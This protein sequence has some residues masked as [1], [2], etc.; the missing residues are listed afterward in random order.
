MTDIPRL[1]SAAA[2][3]I[4][5]LTGCSSSPSPGANPTGST[6]PPSQSTAQQP[7][8]DGSAPSVAGTDTST[9]GIAPSTGGTQ[10]GPVAG[11]DPCAVLDAATIGVAIGA[12]VTGPPTPGQTAYGP[13]CIWSAKD[14]SVTLLLTSADKYDSFKQLSQ[15]VGQ[16]VT[17]V[18]GVGDAAWHDAKHPGSPSVALWVKKGSTAFSLR[19][20]LSTD[21]ATWGRDKILATL[22]PLAGT[23]IAGTVIAGR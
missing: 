10:S 5:C 23:V 9:P 22:R 6:S 11:A 7:A 4:L 21:D 12:A 8:A 2:V 3:L 1:G 19:L 18:T 15:E 13:N 16:P 17:D 20:A 14:R